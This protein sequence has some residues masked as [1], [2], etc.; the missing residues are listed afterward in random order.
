MVKYIT[1][2]RL[3]KKNKKNCEARR[4]GEVGKGAS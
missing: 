1:K 4:N 3:P 2:M